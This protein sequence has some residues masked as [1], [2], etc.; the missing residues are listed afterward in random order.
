[1]AD[2]A[3]REVSSIFSCSHYRV[4]FSLCCHQ[5]FQLLIGYHLS[6]LAVK[7]RALAHRWQDRRRRV[8]GGEYCSQSGVYSRTD[9][10]GLGSTT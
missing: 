1:M 3:L 9:G 6:H 10:T 8:A 7:G 2:E 4:P 5:L